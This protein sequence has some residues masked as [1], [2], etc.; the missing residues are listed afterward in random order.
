[1]DDWL[2]FGENS[3]ECNENVRQTLDILIELGFKI[4]EQKSVPIPSQYCRFL[5]FNFDSKNLR[6][7]IPLEKRNQ[8]AEIIISTSRKNTCRI[9]EFASV[10][11][12]LT[13]V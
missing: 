3:E 5:G 8:I 7:E 2:L 10:I 13:A 12:K 4:S 9:D 1:M 11:G 6:L